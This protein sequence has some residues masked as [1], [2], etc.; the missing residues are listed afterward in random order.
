MSK[1]NK[2]S[3][4]ID[5]CKYSCECKRSVCPQQCCKQS[6]SQN[7]RLPFCSNLPQPI[8][9]PDPSLN[10]DGENCLSCYLKRKLVTKASDLNSVIVSL[11]NPELKQFLTTPLTLP[12]CDAAKAQYVV[13]PPVNPLPAAKCA[14]PPVPTDPIP[15]A[16]R[17]ILVIGG[18]KGIG[19]TVAEYLSENG[20]EVI[21]TSSHPD[22]YPPLPPG[23]KYTLSKQALDVR[24]ESCVNAFF[25][26]VIRPLGVI[27]GMI[28][29]PGMHSAGLLHDYTGDDLRNALELK[30]FGFQRCVKA[31]IPYLRKGQ[32]PRVITFSSI[33]GGESTFGFAAAAYSIPYHAIVMQNDNFMLEE[34]IL[35]GCNE[36]SNPITFS[37]VE[38][39]VTKSTIGLYQQLKPSQKDINNIWVN[40]SFSF[41]GCLQANGLAS[42]GVQAYDPIYIAIDMYN[43]LRAKQPAVRYLTG[44]PNGVIP[45]VTGPVSYPE[46]LQYANT[47]SQDELLNTSIIPIPGVI[48]NTATIN[49]LKSITYS[50]YFT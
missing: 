32:N 46:Y 27:D 13:D 39:I 16:N 22:C 7:L 47:V 5:C 1:C 48:V 25:D 23:T 44:N 28:F 50:I 43:I 34:R 26:R 21:A 35:Y 31:A 37:I 12:T 9:P 20:F 6:C 36:I 4:T 17:R 8:S 41:D 11:T 18:A 24:T 29:L 40:Y 42:F 10:L 3:I 14:F 30:I 2:Q 33:G 38:G 49:L 19:K 45:G 15:V